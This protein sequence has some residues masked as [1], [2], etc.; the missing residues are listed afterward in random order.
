MTEYFLNIE[1]FLYIRIELNIFCYL[2]EILTNIY[3]ESK[4][5]WDL[6]QIMSK[7]RLCF[8]TLQKKGLNPTLPTPTLLIIRGI[9]D[10]YKN[11][12]FLWFN[13]LIF[14]FLLRRPLSSNAR[15]GVNRYWSHQNLHLLIHIDTWAVSIMNYVI[16]T[17]PIL[18]PQLIDTIRNL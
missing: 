14:W 5:R 15:T 2:K 13:F 16:Y 11:L 3:I 12:C 6:V 8:Q 9:R 7:N 18:E 10:I 17:A 4:Y 1:L